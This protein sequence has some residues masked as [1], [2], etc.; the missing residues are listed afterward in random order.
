MTTMNL[1]F[2]HKLAAALCASALAS[3]VL[4]QGT[5][6]AP[7]PAATPAPGPAAAPAA[8]PSSPAKKE[9]VAKILK[10]QQPAIELLGRNMAEQPA[11]QLMQQAAQALQR[12]PADKREAVARDIEADLRKYAEENGPL[13][14]ARAVRIA[15]STLG[16]LLEERFT[17]DELRQVIQLLESPVN[18]KFQGMTGDMQRVLSEKLVAEMGSEIGPKLRATEASVAKRLGITA[19]PPGGAASAPRASPQAPK[20]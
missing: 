7:A 14:S 16:V 20:K 8:L 17:E 19:V 9:L 2:K 6:P 15:P 13:V 12:V 4:A 1:F 10:L 3:Q 11:A 5:A 18:R